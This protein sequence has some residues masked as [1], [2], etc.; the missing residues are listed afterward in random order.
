MIASLGLKRQSYTTQIDNYDGLA[1]LFQILVRINTIYIDFSRDIWTYIS[2]NYFKQKVVAN[3]VGSSAMPHK[4]NPIDFENAEGNLGLANAILGYL[5]Q[6]LPISR[7]QRDLTDSTV[8][9]NIGVPFGHI[10]VALKSLQK[11]INK[12]EVN[13]AKIEQ[14]LSDNWAVVAEAIQT[15][16]KREKFDKPY[17]LLKAFSRG[18]GKLSKEDFDQFIDSLDATNDL[19]TELRAI[20]PFNYIGY[21]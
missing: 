10:M 6:K 1:E 9:R 8:T 21:A 19:K 18:K 17:E 5:S 16:L 15:I 14:D 11:G 2:L 3:E 12:L 13:K 20:T 7:L 4:V